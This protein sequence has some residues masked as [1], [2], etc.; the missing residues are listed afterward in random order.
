MIKW[1]TIG[2]L[3]PISLINYFTSRFSYLK[4]WGIECISLPRIEIELSVIF[5]RIIWWIHTFEYTFSV[6]GLFCNPFVEATQT[7]RNW[8]IECSIAYKSAM[9]LILV[10]F[11]SIICVAPLWRT[12]N[13][14][15]GNIKRCFKSN[16]YWVGNR[17][18]IEVAPSR[19]VRVQT[20]EQWI[21]AQTIYCWAEY[22]AVNCYQLFLQLTCTGILPSQSSAHV[23]LSVKQTRAGNIKRFK[24]NQKNIIVNDVFERAIY[25]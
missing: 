13:E 24:F 25:D 16:N 20:C 6:S 7:R 3:I 21:L 1:N 10:N 17:E 23:K 4:D 12:G 8:I 2:R 9:K 19:S 22:R 11:E 14:E 18:W 5:L 15:L